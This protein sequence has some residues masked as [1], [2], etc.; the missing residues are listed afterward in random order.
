MFSK[1]MATSVKDGLFWISM[2]CWMHGIRSTAISKKAFE[3]KTKRGGCRIAKAEWMIAKPHSET[4]WS[5]K[6]WVQFQFLSLP[7]QGGENTNSSI[8]LSPP[9]ACP[10]APAHPP[11]STSTL[12]LT[13]LLFNRAAPASHIAF[14]SPRC[15]SLS[16]HSQLPAGNKH[17]QDMTSRNRQPNLVGTLPVSTFL[18]RGL[19]KP[20]FRLEACLFIVF[21]RW[22]DCQMHRKWNK[23]D[24]G[25]I[26]SCSK[27]NGAPH[28]LNDLLPF[29][30][31]CIQCV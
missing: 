3:Q 2:P 8:S 4:L 15:N 23:P 31:L 14:L 27:C 30:F 20:P 18:F 25:T 21:W 24:D 19:F 6:L 16:S 11:P 26:E 5:W 9:P 1:D 29:C 12:T 7:T 10:P 17:D 13:L 28:T 22:L